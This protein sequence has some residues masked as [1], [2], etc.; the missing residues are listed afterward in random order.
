MWPFTDGAVK[1][2]CATHQTNAYAIENRG[3]NLMFVHIQSFIHSKR[4][5]ER[6]HCYSL[7]W[8]EQFRQ[9]TLMSNFKFALLL[10]LLLLLIFRLCAAISTIKHKWLS[11]YNLLIAR[12]NLSVYINIMLDHSRI[13]V[14][15]CFLFQKVSW[16][17]RRSDC[18]NT[19]QYYVVWAWHDGKK[20]V[21]KYSAVDKNVKLI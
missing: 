7:L 5:I 13:S 1:I 10:L 9:I 11:L 3:K 4:H 19:L 2:M 16:L 12:T 8:T 15:T 21:R 18:L 17:R 20:V 14:S 6:L